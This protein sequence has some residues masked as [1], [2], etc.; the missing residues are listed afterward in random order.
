M[1]T[2]L[3]DGN[4]TNEFAEALKDDA[5]ELRI[6]CPFI[7]AGALQRLLQHNPKKIQVITRFNLPDIADRVSDIA[8][9][10]N[11]LDAGANVRGVKNLHA[12]LYLFGK[13]RA[14]IT[15]ANLT[16][17]ALDSNHEFGMVTTDG[18]AVEN[19]S[20]YFNNLWCRAGADLLPDQLDDW[21]ITMTHYREGGGRPKA[22]SRLGDFGVDIGIDDAGP[23][24]MP[25]AVHDDVQAFVKFLGTSDD[26]LPPSTSTEDEIKGAGC[27][28]SVGY[29]DYADGRRPRAVQDGDIVFIG[30][31]TQDQQ[32]TPVS[33]DIHVFGR[34]IGMA[35]RPG[36]DDATS[37]DLELRHWRARWPHYNRI[38]HAEFVDGTI[39]NGVSLYELM[40][41][42]DFNSFASTQ[43]HASR[44]EGNTNPRAAIQRQPHVKL[45]TQGLSWLSERLQAA[46]DAHGKVSLESIEGLDWPD[47]KTSSSPQP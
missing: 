46:F 37:A 4:W 33:N 1:P 24:H 23:V 21:D 15:S 11:L 10:R 36:R 8:A 47:S 16:Q 25:T 30:R 7:K 43:E 6:I 41:A 31:L 44:G 42:L 14:I 13:R 2:R 45:S 34:A 39:G 22:R 19:C 5:S 29:P 32:R 27:H 20:D 26:R 40:E 3:V 12:K 17:A 38:Y 9:L 35:H 28:W 18:A